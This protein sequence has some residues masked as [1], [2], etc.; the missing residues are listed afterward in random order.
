VIFLRIGSAD[1]ADVS[2]ELDTL[3]GQGPG[4]SKL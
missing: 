1:A 3:S 4:H 2:A